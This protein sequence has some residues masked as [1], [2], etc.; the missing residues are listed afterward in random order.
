MGKVYKLK[1]KLDTYRTF[2]FFL[3]FFKLLIS[4]WSVIEAVCFWYIVKH[5]LSSVRYCTVA[6][7]SVTFYKVPEQH[8]RV[9]LVGL[10]MRL[11][12]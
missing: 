3:F 12:L 2:I 5:D 7:T 1:K 10:Y 9:Y 6:Y 8:G 4:G 11:K